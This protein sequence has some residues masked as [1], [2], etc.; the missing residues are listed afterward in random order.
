MADIEVIIETGATVEAEIETGATVQANIDNGFIGSLQASD[1]GAGNVT[2]YLG[3][4]S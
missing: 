2:V 3:V 1:D 4:E